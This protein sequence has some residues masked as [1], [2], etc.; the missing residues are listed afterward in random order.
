MADMDEFVLMKLTCESVDIMCTVNK[1]Y[2]PFVVIER[3]KKVLYL[4][5]L[6]VLYGCVR[7]ALLWY[8]LFAGTL[9]ELG[10]AL[11]PYDSCVANQMIEGSQCT[12]ACTSTTPKYRTSNR[13]WRP[14]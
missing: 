4:Q 13:T 7:S 3:G 11:N 5:L 14:T 9:K 10:F 1:K 2:T 12:I 8:K 6:K